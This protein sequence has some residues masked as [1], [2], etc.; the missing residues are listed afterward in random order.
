MNP[1]K[2]IKEYRRLKKKYQPKKSYGITKLNELAK[3]KAGR[4]DKAYNMIKATVEKNNKKNT[5]KTRRKASKGVK[6]TT[7]K[8]K[9]RRPKENDFFGGMDFKL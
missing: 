9:G 3:S 6:F 2:E 1:F 7:F 4:K 5:P 8:G